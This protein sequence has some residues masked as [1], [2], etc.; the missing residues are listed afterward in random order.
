MHIHILGIC[1]T[2]MAGIAKIAKALGH[3]VTG[4]DQNVYPPMSTVLQNLHIEVQGGYREESIPKNVDLVVFGNAMSRGNPAVEF[5]L[6][7]KIPFVSGPQWLYDYVLKKQHV[8]AVSGT[9]GKTTTTALLAWILESAGLSPGFLIGGAPKNFEETARLGAGKFFVI[10][11][12]EYD[13]AFYDKRSKFLH[14][15]PTTLVVN[16]L[17]F[18]H[19]D[20]FEDLSAIQKQFQYLLRTVPSSGAV[21]FP[22][23]SEAIQGVVS[24]GCWSTQVPLQSP[25]GWRAEKIAA[26]Y[27][28]FKI[29]DTNNHETS[30]HWCMIGKH[31]MQNALSAAA[32][33]SRVGVSLN[34]IKQG[35]ESF[36]GVK[37]RME[38]RGVINEITVYD[39]FA[40]HPS[41]IEL[42]INGLRARVGNDRIIVLAQLA[43][44]TMAQGVHQHVLGKA[45]LA[46]DQV[47]ILHPVDSQWDILPTLNALNGKGHAHKSVAD[48]LAHV[49]PE[50]SA[51]DHVIIMSNKGFDGLH[52]RLLTS[53]RKIKRG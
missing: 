45:F 15:H 18:D 26:D 33:A 19:A 44:N 16:N 11:A 42:T 13:T 31:N 39:D 52:E 51:K 27:S 9:H 17:E 20:I 12:D 32:A 34:T 21:I 48:L 40:H 10:E 5:V 7:K 8:L 53:L 38:V 30:I 14:Y 1:G 4:S 22:N 35:I 46:A 6:N 36:K 41:A 37:R 50:L 2:F 49:L 25:L 29:I 28:Q 24:R 3:T 43:S 23:D 47:H